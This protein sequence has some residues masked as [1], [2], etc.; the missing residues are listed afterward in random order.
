MKVFA[1]FDDFWKLHKKSHKLK[2]ENSDLEKE[3][4]SLIKQLEEERARRI[5]ETLQLKKTKEEF[6]IKLWAENVMREDLKKEVACVKTVYQK[7]SLRVYD[8]RWVAYEV[9]GKCAKNFQ[10]FRDFDYFPFENA[11]FLDEN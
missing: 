10:L 7:A 3:N 6:D 8:S 4:K 9:T 1:K 5:S 11:F 2:K